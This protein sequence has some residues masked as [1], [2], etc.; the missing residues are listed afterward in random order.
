MPKLSAKETLHRHHDEEQFLLRELDNAPDMTLGMSDIRVRLLSLQSIA[1]IKPEA[2]KKRVQRLIARL[3]DAGLIVR[4]GRLQQEII[5]GAGERTYY[6]RRIHDRTSFMQMASLLDIQ[7]ESQAAMAATLLLASN[8][9]KQQL[10]SQY[11]EKLQPIL[12]YAEEVL[13]KLQTKSQ[14]SGFQSWDAAALVGALHVTQKGIQLRPGPKTLDALNGA[15]SIMDQLQAAIAQH[16][17]IHFSYLGKRRKQ[18]KHYEAGPLGIVFRSPKVYLVGAVIH[19][20]DSPQ[21]VRAWSLDRISNLTITSGRFS[22]PDDFVLADYVEQ[23][24]NL[25][26]L[27]DPTRPD[28][29]SISFR[30]LPSPIPGHGEGLITD[31]FLDLTLEGQQQQPRQHK[32]KSLTVQLRRKDTIEFRRWLKGYG[33]AITN[34][35]GLPRW[36]G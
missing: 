14:S 33:D 24:S 16:K 22:R 12:N 20:E 3:E 6:I 7:G 28:P 19:P 23:E 17:S 13:K 27:W 35:R 9:L 21:S 10:P 31:E 2:Q 8:T 32:D 15:E 36:E 4:L 18:R 25:E 11:Y 26:S 5:E 29:V 30:V 34:V 1:E